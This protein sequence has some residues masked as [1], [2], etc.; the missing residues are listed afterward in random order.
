MRALRV[1]RGAW[2]HAVRIV[3]ERLEADGVETVGADTPAVPGGQDGDVDAELRELGIA[4]RSGGLTA[5]WAAALG[6]HL[7]APVRAS[8]RA[9][10][11]P[12][13]ATTRLSLVDDR[14]LLVHDAVRG[15][16]GPRELDVTQLSGHVD[17]VLVTVDDLWPALRR[18]LPPVE[19]LTAPPAPGG[20]SSES[21]RTVLGRA[22]A[23]RLRSGE[24]LAGLPPAARALAEDEEASLVVVVEAWP[25]PSAPTVVWSRWWSVASGRLLDVQLRDAEVELVER[26]PGAVAAE[27]RWALVGAIDATSPATSGADGA[28]DGV[29]SD[30]R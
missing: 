14:V 17:V 3:Q 21:T 15:E 22:D 11:G 27:L 28:R 7:L 19:Q 16:P 13:A 25:T 12:V 23:E 10:A 26:A 1:T 4:D 29:R 2:A 9:T 8:L 6:Q 24:G 18:L 20:A 30:D 5:A